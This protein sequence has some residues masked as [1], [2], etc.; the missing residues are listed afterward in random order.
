MQSST[1]SYSTT[2]FYA[3]LNDVVDSTR[4]EKQCK[5]I[6]AAKRSRQSNCTLRPDA[7]GRI[8]GKECHLLAFGAMLEEELQ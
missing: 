3:K 4:V 6:E 1:I 7:S 8:N 5:A 2:T